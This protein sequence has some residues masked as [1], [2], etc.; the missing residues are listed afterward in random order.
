MTSQ[1]AFPTLFVAAAA[2]AASLSTV[3]K[4]E[5]L[6]INSL[7]LALVAVSVHCISLAVYRLYLSPLAKFPGPKLAAVTLWYEFYYDVIKRGRYTWQIAKLH[8][9]YGVLLQPFGILDIKAPLANAHVEG[10]LYVSVPTNCT[11]TTTS[12]EPV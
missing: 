2:A 5:F 3:A 6:S 10:Q 11:S 4:M 8:E 12:Q 1:P 7:L 9:R